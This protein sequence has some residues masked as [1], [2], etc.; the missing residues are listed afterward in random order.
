MRKLQ[1]TAYYFCC[2]LL[3]IWM[4]SFFYSCSRTPQKTPKNSTP[5]P[6]TDTVKK[7]TQQLYQ[8]EIEK[9]QTREL[10][11]DILKSMTSQLN[12]QKNLIRMMFYFTALLGFIILVIWI[13]HLIILH[14][15]TR[16]P[17][18]T[19]LQQNNR[20]L[21]SESFSIKKLDQYLTEKKYS[22]AILYLHRSTLFYLKKQKLI[23]NKNRTNRDAYKMI[24]NPSLKETFKKI[25]TIS[26]KI[27]FD[28]HRASKIE[29]ERC[30]QIYQKNF[31]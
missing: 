26:E 21:F 2:L 11:K 25:Y 19:Q 9:A 30:Y 29:F 10:R 27:L 16:K 1:K 8:M 20:S 13:S 15:R 12:N 5:P 7:T 18:F 23:M 4:T 22:E 24:N 14:V 31:S 28:G 3:F 17:V 6:Q